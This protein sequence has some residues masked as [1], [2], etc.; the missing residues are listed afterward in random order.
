M[1]KRKKSK[2]ATEGSDGFIESPE[3]VLSDI[4]HDMEIAKEVKEIY[5]ARIKAEKIYKKH[6]GDAPEDKTLVEEILSKID[7]KIE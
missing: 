6:L 7:K 5:E 1:E 2:T 4:K 3:Q